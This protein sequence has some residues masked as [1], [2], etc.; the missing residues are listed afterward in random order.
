VVGMISRGGMGSRYMDR[1]YRDKVYW[2]EENG[3]YLR[4][5]GTLV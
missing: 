3:Y 1:G 2:K 4:G 5:L